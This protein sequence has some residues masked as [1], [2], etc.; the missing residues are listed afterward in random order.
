M[1]KVDDLRVMRERN[2]E[3]CQHRLKAQKPVDK[4]VK[5]KKAKIAAKSCVTDKRVTDN[6]VT[7]KM[8]IICNKPFAAKRA[9]ATI[10]SPACQMRKKRSAKTSV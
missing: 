7:D 5:L 9:D 1:G 8:C 3:E 4:R 6:S 2:F 10:C